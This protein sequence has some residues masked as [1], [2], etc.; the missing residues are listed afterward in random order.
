MFRDPGLF[1][2]PGWITKLM[3]EGI[4]KSA[5]CHTP[6]TTPAREQHNHTFYIP[7]CK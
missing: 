6:A 3:E 4:H 1:D 7:L 5:V 2:A